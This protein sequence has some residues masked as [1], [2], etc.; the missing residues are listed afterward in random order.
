M[1][2]RFA[3]CCDPTRAA[4]VHS[5][6]GSAIEPPFV[7]CARQ[8]DE[9]HQKDHDTLLS[10]PLR[11]YSMNSMLPGDFVLYGTEA[12]T[13]A[14]C[15]F[16]RR[17][18]ARAAKMGVKSVCMGSGAARSVPE[19]MTREEAA[20]RLAALMARFCAIAD[21]Y[22]MR[23]SI[24]P[25]RAFETNFIH[26]MDDAYDIIRRIPECKN[27]GINPD[28]Y[29]MLE[30]GEP[31]SNL[32][33][34]RDYVSNVHIAEPFTRAYPRPGNAKA[35]ALYLDFLRALRDADYQGIVSIEALTQDFVSDVKVALPYLQSLAASI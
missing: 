25:L 26:T 27:L 16:A 18:M 20:D 11:A 1:N 3:A 28:M 5:L 35:E 22:E 31:F 6:G 32:I 33:K 30:G 2:I 23:V 4:L 12:Q 9:E 29:H 17:G 24:E 19:G 34:Y 21:E 15:D 8:T 13:A 7:I 14:V 10:S